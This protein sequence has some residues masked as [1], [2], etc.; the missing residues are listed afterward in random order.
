MPQ[1]P[2]D[3]INTTLYDCCHCEAGLTPDQESMAFWPDELRRSDTQ[4]YGHVAYELM[5]GA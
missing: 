3:A 4:L 5:E 1:P 2:R